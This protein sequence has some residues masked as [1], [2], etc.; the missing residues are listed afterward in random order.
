MSVSKKQNKTK[1]D[2]FQ[3][4]RLHSEILGHDVEAKEVSVD[5][6]A[7]HRHAIKVLVRFGCGAEQ[8]PADICRLMETQQFLVLW[9]K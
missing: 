2:L 3:E 7:G 9:A 8:T 4:R 1:K 6:G 5:A